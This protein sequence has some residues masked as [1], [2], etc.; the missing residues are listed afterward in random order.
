MYA[1][2]PDGYAC[3]RFHPNGRVYL[4][5]SAA[6]AAE[7]RPQLGPSNPDP[8]VGQY[9]GA[10]RFVVQRRFERPIVFTVLAADDDGIT[11]R[12]TATDVA[13]TG[14]FRYTFNP[15]AAAG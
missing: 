3:L 6:D 7:A 5:P 2:G 14:Q 15:D 11:V 8:T 12:I 13:Q 4:A 1:G 9:T 10:G